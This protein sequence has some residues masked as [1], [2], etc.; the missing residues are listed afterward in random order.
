MREKERG[1]NKKTSV[2][3]AGLNNRGNLLRISE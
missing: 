2:G 1:I 3:T